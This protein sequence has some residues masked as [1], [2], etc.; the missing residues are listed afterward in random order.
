VPIVGA[1]AAARPSAAQIARFVARAN[2]MLAAAEIQVLFVDD[3]RGPDYETI[4]AATMGG[5]DPDVE[6]WAAQ[7]NLVA[8]QHPGKIVVYFRPAARDQC[9]ALTSGDFVEMTPDGQNGCGIPDED[10]LGNLIWRH[11]GLRDIADP[12]APLSSVMAERLVRRLT[13]RGYE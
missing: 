7:A 13:G 5:A 11:L 12:S 8:G 10:R 6:R 3:E 1:G 2:Q 9:G 4:P